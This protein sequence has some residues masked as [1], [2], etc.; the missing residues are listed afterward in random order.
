MVNLTQSNV[1]AREVE[2]RSST[3]QRMVGRARREAGTAT[4]T[5]PLSASF[6]RRRSAEVSPL[7]AA[8]TGRGVRSFSEIVGSQNRRTRQ[9]GPMAADVPAPGDDR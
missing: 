2:A 7:R 5:R 9:S 6:W 8:N 3:R 1:E 4:S